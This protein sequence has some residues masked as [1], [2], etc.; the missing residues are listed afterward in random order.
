MSDEWDKGNLNIGFPHH[1]QGRVSW[2]KFGSQDIIELAYTTNWTFL[3][4]Y[5]KN[6][7][8][9]DKILRG[10]EVYSR[11]GNAIGSILI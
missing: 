5:V 6:P 10:V 1:S 7:K 8:A 3:A 9:R 4:N 11:W 2:K